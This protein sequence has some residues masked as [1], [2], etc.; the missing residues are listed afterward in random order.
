MERYSG[1][2]AFSGSELNAVFDE[3]AEYVLLE[4]KDLPQSV[5]E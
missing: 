1:V 2:L 5:W 4:E 3:F